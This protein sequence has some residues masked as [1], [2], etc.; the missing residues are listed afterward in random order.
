MCGSGDV[1]ATRRR[2]IAESIPPTLSPNQA[3]NLLQRQLRRL[4]EEIIKLPEYDPGVEAWMS[5]TLDILNQTFGQPN[6]MRHPKTADFTHSGARQIATGWG[7]SGGVDHANQQAFL[8][9]QQKRAAL[10]GAYIEQLQDSAPPSAASASEVFPLHSEIE[11]VSGRLFQNRHYKEAALEAY[12]RVID[13]VK[14]MSQLREDGDPL[15]NRAF[16]CERQIPIIEFND[17][18][19]DAE[20]DEQRGIMYL[21]KGLVCLRNMK[22]H[23]NSPVDDPVRARELLGLASLLM[24]LLGLAHVNRTP[25]KDSV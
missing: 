19:S 12:I 23:T 6:G 13:E 15:M 8:R 24:R 17:L 11:R 1:M 9:E 2:S 10:L 22:A 21:F 20:R 16:G 25:K 5:T 7:H 4:E 14:K 18:S 3:I